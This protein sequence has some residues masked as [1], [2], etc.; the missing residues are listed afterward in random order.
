MSILED[1]RAR[2]YDVRPGLSRAT[3]MPA[4]RRILTAAATAAL[5]LAAAAPA[6]GATIS[7]RRCV[8]VVPLAGVKNMPITGTGFTP[9]D[10]VIVRYQSTRSASPR[11]S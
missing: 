1:A 8:A 4:P 10:G 2:Q 6:D 3:P 11:R 7:T 9:D 5:I